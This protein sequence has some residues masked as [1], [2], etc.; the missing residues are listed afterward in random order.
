MNDTN[1]DFGRCN[2]CHEVHE[3]SVDCW[4]KTQEQEAEAELDLCP[5]AADGVHQYFEIKK[6]A[7]KQP[8]IDME[9]GGVIK[10]RVA[11]GILIKCAL[12]DHSKELLEG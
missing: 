7:Y 8:D 11:Q 10:G 4:E 3:S 6:L 1:S 5:K 9:A 2:Y 12:C